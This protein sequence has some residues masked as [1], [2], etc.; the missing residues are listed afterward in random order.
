ME[1]NQ[2]ETALSLL[3]VTMQL[4]QVLKKIVKPMPAKTLTTLL[5]SKTI[6]ITSTITAG[7]GVVKNL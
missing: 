4:T 5:C 1:K 7:L 6:N 3:K 2:L